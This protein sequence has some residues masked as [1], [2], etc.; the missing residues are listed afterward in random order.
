M[1]HPRSP[2]LRRP[3]PIL[4]SLAAGVVLASCS[5]GFGQMFGALDI[6]PPDP[7]STLAAFPFDGS[8]A[9]SSG[10]P[11]FVS[12]TS[13]PAPSY[14]TGR[15]GSAQGALALGAAV[16]SSGTT[17]S[18]NYRVTVGAS[19]GPVSL[20]FWLYIDPGA[21]GAQVDL[22]WP[23]PTPLGASESYDYTITF[24][25]YAT[26][27]AVSA[28]GLNGGIATGSPASSGTWHYIAVSW[29][30]LGRVTA[31]FD[32]SRVEAPMNAPIGKPRKITIDIGIASTGG[33][34]TSASGT[35]TNELA[36][37][38]LD[39]YAGTLTSNQ[40]Q[41]LYQGKLTIP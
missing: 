10:S 18:D 8:L 23:T 2:W 4:A 37:D 13:M 7:A 38:D 40:V 36:V 19:G 15:D 25:Q 32:G 16:S 29:N 20:G 31:Y 24:S 21:A 35:R 17:E 39:L 14:V 1:R 12:T 26:D 22:S 27:F 9:S 11:A 6:V 41:Q 33:S 3:G 5:M 30:R 28:D 34:L